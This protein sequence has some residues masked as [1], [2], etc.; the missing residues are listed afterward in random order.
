MTLQIA[1]KKLNMHRFNG[2]LFVLLAMYTIALIVFFVEFLFALVVETGLV[3]LCEES[4]DSSINLNYCSLGMRSR[5][6]DQSR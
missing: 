5:K 6:Q 2:V 1:Y 3:L 4:K